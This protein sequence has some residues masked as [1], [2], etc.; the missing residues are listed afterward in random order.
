[1]GLEPRKGTW[2]F[3][4][5]LYKTGVDPDPYYFETS[6]QSSV[7]ERVH[8]LTS[9]V[10]FEKNEEEFDLIFIDGAHVFSIV[11]RD[12][13]NSLKHLNKGGTIVLHD[14]LPQTE[15]AQLPIVQPGS[16][17]G[18]AWKAF[19]KARV[20]CGTQHEF[21]V[22]DED[23]G[24]GVIRKSSTPSP[25]DFIS[26]QNLTWENFVINKG[27]WMNPVSYEEFQRRI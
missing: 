13:L 7:N 5:C 27:H 15:R 22:I 11:Y 20:F 25:I 6:L 24:C 12:I 14:M 8:N 17:N 3:I 16:W 4:D 23:E 19:V 10:F 18:D 1:M 9:D 26:D 2:N 21:F